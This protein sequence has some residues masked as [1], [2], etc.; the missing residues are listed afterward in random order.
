MAKAKRSARRDSLPI[1]SPRLSSPKPGLPPRVSIPKRTTWYR[2]PEPVQDAR[3]W[4]PVPKSNRSYR[5]VSG[6]P[7]R[8]VS[9][10]LPKARHVAKS[11][12][13][14]PFQAVPQS[15]VFEKPKTVTLCDRRRVRR[16]VIMATG[17]GGPQRKGKRTPESD[18]R[19]K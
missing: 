14:E 2:V 7:A 8:V 18:V 1:T 17:N 5:T 19:C 6:T 4:N 15:L 12:P 3:I 13:L 16:E 11:A 9:P 10:P